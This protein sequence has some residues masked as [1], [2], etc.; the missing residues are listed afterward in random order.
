MD[1]LIYQ[2]ALEGLEL[3]KQRIDEQIKHVR[4]LLAGTG[5]TNNAAPAQTSVKAG[6]RKKRR[7]WSSD[8]KLRM[9]EA[10][11]KRWAATREKQAMENG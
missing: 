5:K 6:T 1:N 10:Q 2:A 4:E 9:S 7:K 3:Q 8:S 11:K